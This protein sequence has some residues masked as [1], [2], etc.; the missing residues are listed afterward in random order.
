MPLYNMDCLSSS[1]LE[2]SPHFHLRLYENLL[3]AHT[4]RTP[5]NSDSLHSLLSSKEGASLHFQEL[6]QQLTSQYQSL[7]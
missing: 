5:Q 6:Q 2:R 7:S 3:T 1:F 4:S